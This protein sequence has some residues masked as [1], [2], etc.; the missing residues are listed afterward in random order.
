MEVE[1]NWENLFHELRDILRERYWKDLIVKRKSTPTKLE[2]CKPVSNVFEY[3]FSAWKSGLDKRSETAYSGSVFL[4]SVLKE[5]GRRFTSDVTEANE[6]YDAGKKLASFLWEE[7][8]RASSEMNSVIHNVNLLELHSRI[9]EYLW[10]E[11][12]RTRFRR[13]RE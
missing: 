13:V 2:I 10:D 8:E 4:Y 5:T 1:H 11:F 7:L 6:L 9:S 3:V 12:K